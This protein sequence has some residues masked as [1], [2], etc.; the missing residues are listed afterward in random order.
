MT[1]IALTI[2]GSDPSG[3]GLHREPRQRHASL[4]PISG[5]SEARSCLFPNDGRLE[6]FPQLQIKAVASPRNHRQ[7]T[8]RNGLSG[9][10]LF[11]FSSLT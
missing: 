2:A 1:P 7:L 8:P 9:E 4:W 11:V 5:R 3:G 10:L 6:Q